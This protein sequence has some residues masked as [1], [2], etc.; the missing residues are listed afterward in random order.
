VV[1][2]P[3]GLAL[4]GI[5]FQ[6]RAIQVRRFAP[7]YFAGIKGYNRL[8]MSAEFYESFLDYRYILIY[9]LD[10]FVFSD[11]L[12][13]WCAQGYDYIGAPWVGVDWAETCKDDLPAWYRHRGLRKLLRR[14]ELLVGNGGLS[15]RK[16]RSFLRA[17]RLL[18]RQ[19][20]R[21]RYNE[22]AFW[23]ILVPIYNPFFRIPPVS[24][25]RRF[26]IELHP[27]ESYFRNGETLPFGCHA[28]EKYDPEFW[29]DQIRGFGYSI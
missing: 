7:E 4:E 15:L 21:W 28:W 9:Q 22:D 29:R 3:E 8:M 26:A 19:A 14:E 6:G 10:A 17:V 11:S 13:G 23:A 25:A 27:E 20:G 24:L 16:V 12:A 18:R 1:V 5:D 2:A